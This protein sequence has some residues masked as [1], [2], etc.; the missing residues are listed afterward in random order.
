MAVTR[1]S[2]FARA[3]AIAAAQ[4]LAL[5]ARQQPPV[6]VGAI[7]QA[8]GAKAQDPRMATGNVAKL[9]QYSDRRAK[10]SLIKGDNR[11]KNIYEALVAID[12]Q[13]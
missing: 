8:L 11:R 12:D 9:F 5:K 1:R 13:I 7:P 4:G 3:G 10:V 6:D 2:F